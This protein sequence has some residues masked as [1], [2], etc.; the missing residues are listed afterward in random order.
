MV[1]KKNYLVFF[2]F[3]KKNL[4]YDV[5]FINYGYNIVIYYFCL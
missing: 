3:N 1:N 2:K 4:M 5:L